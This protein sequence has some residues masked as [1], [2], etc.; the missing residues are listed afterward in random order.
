M[1]CFIINIFV[2][3]TIAMIGL[4]CLLY[5]C[6]ESKKY[7][8]YLECIEVIKIMVN[9]D[10]EL[11]KC[12][13]CI[14]DDIHYQIF[15]NTTTFNP[16]IH[17]LI[18][19]YDIDFLE[20]IIVTGKYNGTDTYLLRFNGTSSMSCL[21]GTYKNNFRI[22]TISLNF[23]D[24]I[25]NP[26]SY[27]QFCSRKYDICFG[28]ELQKY[29][30]I[31][32]IVMIISIISIFFSF[33][34]LLF[35]IYQN[36]MIKYDEINNKIYPSQYNFNFTENP[37]SPNFN[38]FPHTNDVCQNEAGVELVKIDMPENDECVLCLKKM[39]NEKDNYRLHCT[40]SAHATCIIKWIERNKICPI[41]K[42]VIIID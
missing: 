34:L 26:R 40:H 35:I 7:N 15:D 29:G 22:D 41:C 25:M 10:N 13:T 31:L 23:N 39:N 42:S 3:I 17:R 28:Y 6:D 2:C 14:I 24:D 1:K 19:K 9:Y 4:I 5:Y 38:E 37:K 16:M 30:G 27:P 32:M 11:S 33:S 20:N 36:H 12:D 21:F 8:V 18:Q